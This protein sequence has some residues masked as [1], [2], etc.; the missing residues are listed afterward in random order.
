MERKVPTMQFSV[1]MK[2]FKEKWIWDSDTVHFGNV[3]AETNGKFYSAFDGN[4][5]KRL[6]T[7]FN[8]FF[9]V[10]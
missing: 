10:G 5:Y 3:I 4:I 6:L 7:D 9:T 8:I 2:Q 1:N